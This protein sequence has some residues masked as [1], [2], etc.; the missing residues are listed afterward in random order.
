MV[1]AAAS[2]PLWPCE[3]GKQI[4]ED[5]KRNGCACPEFE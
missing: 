1:I 4:D 5:E 2:I 3:H